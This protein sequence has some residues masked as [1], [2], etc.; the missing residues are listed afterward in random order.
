MADEKPVEKTDAEKE[1]DEVR[2]DNAD[3]VEKAKSVP[4][5]ETRPDTKSG[6]TAHRELSVEDQAKVRNL[7]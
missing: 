2:E 4:V 5:L 6:V 7:R 1:S 3:A